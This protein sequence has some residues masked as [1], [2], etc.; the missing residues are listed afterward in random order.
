MFEG[1]SAFENPRG[2]FTYYNMIA[3]RGRGAGDHRSGGEGIVAVPL[4]HIVAADMRY[5]HG[6][7]HTSW[8]MRVRPPDAVYAPVFDNPATREEWRA[9]FQWFYVQAKLAW[10][11]GRDVDDILEEMYDKFYGPAAEPMAG[12]RELIRGLWEETPGDFI[13]DA[14]FQGLGRTIELPGA[15]EGIVALFEEAEKAAAGRFP[16]A[17]RVARDRSIFENSWIMAHDILMER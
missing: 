11:I 8:T 7:G 14:Q 12:Y 6:L 15:R 3:T 4:E 9:N 5:M 2:Y 16:Y 10:D 13:Y 1:W 17:E